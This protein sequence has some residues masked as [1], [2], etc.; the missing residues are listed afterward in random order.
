MHLQYDL[1]DEKFSVLYRFLKK[2]F[3]AI[4]KKLCIPCGCKEIKPKVDLIF[5]CSLNTHALIL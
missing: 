1:F 3:V 4:K 2:G 5:K